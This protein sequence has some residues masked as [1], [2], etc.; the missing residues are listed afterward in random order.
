[1]LQSNTQYGADAY[2]CIPSS[3]CLILK[4]KVW[5]QLGDWLTVNMVSHSQILHAKHFAL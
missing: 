2:Y 4:D 3:D 1:M 5:C